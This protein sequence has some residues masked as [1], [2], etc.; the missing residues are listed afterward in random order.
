MDG[1]YYDG[2]SWRVEIEGILFFSSFVRQSVGATVHV[3]SGDRDFE[4]MQTQ[5]FARS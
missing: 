4:L 2:V 3:Y 5:H 1:G